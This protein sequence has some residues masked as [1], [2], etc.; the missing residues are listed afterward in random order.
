VREK[1]REGW[2]RF[3][4]VLSSL[5]D[6]FHEEPA[7]VLWLY[8]GQAILHVN[9][10]SILIAQKQQAIG[11]FNTWHLRLKSSSALPMCAL[12]LRALL[13]KGIYPF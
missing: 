1:K 7:S 5:W 10:H 6:K 12:A 2:R 3:Q 4:R 9:T 11:D 13:Q 8:K